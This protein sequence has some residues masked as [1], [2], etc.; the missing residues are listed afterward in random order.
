MPD[1]RG[2][3]GKRREHSAAG[4]VEGPALPCY[5]SVLAL[6]HCLRAARSTEERLFSSHR[7]PVIGVVKS[8]GAA[9]PAPPAAWYSPWSPGP[10]GAPAAIQKATP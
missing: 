6:Q 1:N 7:C 2:H 3:M 4:Q 10:S 9:A 8:G 5:G